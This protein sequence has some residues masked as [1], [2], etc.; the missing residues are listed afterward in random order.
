[1]T[2]KIRSDKGKTRK[3]AT[4]VIRVPKSLVARIKESIIKWLN[5]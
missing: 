1:M 3:P 2:R 4:E 5:E